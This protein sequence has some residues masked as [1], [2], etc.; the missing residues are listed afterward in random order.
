MPLP[1]SSAV[2]TGKASPRREGSIVIPNDARANRGPAFKPDYLDA[3]GTSD[4]L[5]R[6]RL[7][8]PLAGESP[9]HGAVR[10]SL[11]ARS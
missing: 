3:P 8:R 6:T 11:Y 9:A 4:C 2:L 7:V 10:K 5:D 1:R